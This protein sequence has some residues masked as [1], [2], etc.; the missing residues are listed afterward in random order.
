MN[1]LL[2]KNLEELRSR[3]PLLAERIESEMAKLEPGDF[4][5]TDVSSGRWVKD[6]SGKAFF[7]RIADHSLSGDCHMV[8]GVG[9][10]PYLFKV[11]RG[12][13]KEALAVVVIEPDLR[14]LLATFSMTSVY[15]ALPRGCRLSFVVWGET[16]LV[17]EAVAYNVVPLGIFLFTQ[18]RK[19]VHRGIAEVEGEAL[20]AL[21]AKFWDVVRYRVE[22]L[23]NS[24]EDTL[25]GIRH[26][27]LNLPRILEGVDGKD[28]V[29]IWKDRP[30]VCVA[31][32]PSLKRN[33]DLLK[34]NEDRFLIVA[35]DTALLP[36]LRRGIVPHAVTTIERNLMYEVWMPSVLEEF[37][38]E[39]RG[40]LL[41]S[42]SVSEPITAGRWPGPVFVVGKMDSPADMWLVN[43]VLKKNTMLSGM[44]VAHMS[45][46]FAVGVGAS[47][48]ALIGQDLSFDDDGETTHMEGAASLTPDG[49][50]RELAYPRLEVEAIG[51]GRVKTHQMWYYFLQIFERILPNFGEDK[52]FQCSE[53]GAVIKGAGCMPLRE[54]MARFGDAQRVP[55]VGEEDVK[56]GSAESE[57]SGILV[58]IG[59]AKSDISFC[60]D[61]LDQ[62]EEEINRVSAPALAPARR[63]QH[64]M[65]VAEL[66]DRLHGANR[67]LAFIGQSYTHLS[68]VVIAK[69][70]F[71]E[72]MEDVR[73]WTKVHLDMVSSHRVNLGFM[74]Q[75]LDYMEAMLSLNVEGEVSMYRGLRDGDLLEPLGE[76]LERFFESGESDLLSPLGLS[77]SDMLCRVDLERQEGVHPE[78]L[79]M[80]AK[81]LALQGRPYEARRLMGR[82]Y[83]MWHDTVAPSEVVA[84][85]FIDWAAIEASHDLV[86]APQ[87]EL[88]ISLLDSARDVMPQWTERIDSLKTQVLESQRRYLDAVKLVP[89]YDLQRR[90][91]ERRN[92]AQEALLRQDLPRAFEEVMAMEEG[93]EK[94]PGDVV[95]HL[96][97]LS[98]TALDCLGCDDPQVDAACR[99]AIDF[100][101]E[102]RDRLVP[103]CFPFDSRMLDYLRDKGIDVVEIQVEG[104][105]VP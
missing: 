25:L 12:L 38:E 1:S 92:A 53:R 11:L 70:R 71:L 96:R 105:Q 100:I 99:R 35:C 31:S 30:A 32:G 9:Y 14:R 81:F 10:P 103:L 28:L 65:K 5:V 78:L 66:L 36:L 33:V 4:T 104:S 49:I 27:A 40:I 89:E 34:G 62:M 17:D 68:G 48:V 88:A 60:L 61:V 69:T 46:C 76:A 29:R 55:R 82:A 44:S 79:W 13:P 58:R 50:A 101:W 95:P 57:V 26:G 22:S 93:L 77:I 41:V 7:E 97:W 2:R 90:L 51:G 86:R 74:R 47:K 83:G 91:M 21:E 15:M 18:A 59:R 87:F 72:T 102:I 45:M 6:P 37:P 73:E 42:Q 64:A 52:V 23:G 20:S 63:R 24:P 3:Q 75:W 84:G 94:Y 16:A 19:I 54:F 56:F 98:K 80:A 67:A 39:C 43:D 85:F 8:L